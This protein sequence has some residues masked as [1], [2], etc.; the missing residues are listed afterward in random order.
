MDVGNKLKYMVDIMDEVWINTAE[1][2][3]NRCPLWQD[4]APATRK[5][6]YDKSTMTALGGTWCLTI[7]NPI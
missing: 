1:L 2:L 5:E 3:T 7:V 6:L 4:R